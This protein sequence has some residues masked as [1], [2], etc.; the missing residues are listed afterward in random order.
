MSKA[1]IIVVFMIGV[2]SLVASVNMALFAPLG[3]N[4][5]VMRFDLIRLAE[6]QD[7]HRRMW[8]EFIDPHYVEM[9]FKPT[10]G[11]MLEVG[12]TTDG[13]GWWAMTTHQDA[14]GVCAIFAGTPD[15]ILP[16]EEDNKPACSRRRV[17]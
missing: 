8:G 14:S 6:A 12:R 13:K 16:A 15:P 17:R 9:V 11:V 2:F 5:E 1:P 4:Y 7:K 3:S 10:L